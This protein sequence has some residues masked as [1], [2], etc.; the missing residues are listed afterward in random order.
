M[1][2]SAAAWQVYWAGDAA[3]EAAL[4][5]AVAAGLAE[6]LLCAPRGAAP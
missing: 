5:L 3:A 2:G 1:K 4:L 6:V